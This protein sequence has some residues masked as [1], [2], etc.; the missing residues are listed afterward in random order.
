[1]TFDQIL[2]HEWQK[3]ILNRSLAGGRLAHAY[4]FSGPDGVGKRL[5][6]MAL[7]RAIVCDE[8]RGCGDCRACRKIDH[9]N[10][11]D[12]HVL[13]PDG[14]AIKIEQILNTQCL[15]RNLILISRANSS[16]CCANGIFTGGFFVRLVECDVQ[17]QNDRAGTT[18]SQAFFNRYTSFSQHI[19]FVEQRLWRYHYAIAD[20]THNVIAQY[21]TW[22][23]VQHGFL[24][25]DNQ[26][27][28][29][30]MAAKKTHEL[31][32]MCHP[33]LLTHGGLNFEPQSPENGHARIDISATVRVRGQTGVEMEALTAV[34]TAALTIYVMCK[35]VDRGMR[36][37]FKSGKVYH[38]VYFDPFPDMICGIWIGAHAWEVHDLLG[39][40]RDEGY[41]STGRIW[42]YDTRG[43]LAV[44]FDKKDRVRSISL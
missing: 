12:L 40:A 34:S 41:F 22:D 8:Q 10:H 25:A 38:I 18:D 24:F 42:Q 33:L 35:A 20:D 43:F 29:G 19:D 6:A 3:E 28:A 36:I 44:G 4:L 21:A 16:A 15:A 1:M 7:A 32:P 31:V 39:T 23:Q 17:R 37:E 13:E 9:Q 30:I 27:V 26:R 11:P 5:V 14:N 2:G